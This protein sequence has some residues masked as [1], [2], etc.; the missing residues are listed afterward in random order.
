[1]FSLPWAFGLGLGIYY[2][3]LCRGTSKV[4]YSK[5]TTIFSEQHKAELFLPYIGQNNLTCISQSSGDSH[6]KQP[7]YF[8]LLEI[9]IPE[10][11]IQIRWSLEI[12]VTTLCQ[13][14][15]NWCLWMVTDGPVNTLMLSTNCWIMCIMFSKEKTSW[16][17]SKYSQ[18]NSWPHIRLSI[19][20]QFK[21][22]NCHLACNYL[23]D[24]CGIL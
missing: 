21:L 17:K 11:M 7:V 6:I 22:V 24:V 8:V 19:I 10:L 15:L 18:R 5:H 23:L 9:S 2:W 13:S 4:T 16:Q 12:Y 20:A 1:M 14:F 3:C